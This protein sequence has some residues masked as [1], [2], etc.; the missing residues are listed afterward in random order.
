MSI[1]PNRIVYIPGNGGS[2][3]HRK[4]FGELAPQFRDL[5]LKVVQRKFP[6]PVLARAQYWI[7]F[8]RDELKV[9]ERTVL[10][11]H[12]SGAV[13]ALRYAEQYPI[14]G[15]VV[16]APA[17]TDLGIE[18]EKLSGYFDSPWQWDR[19]R[20]N[21]HF[22]GIFAS[23]D[24]PWIPIE[25]A[26]AVRD[27]LMTAEGEALIDYHEYK[28]KGHFRTNSFPALYKYL[29]RRMMRML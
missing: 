18:E 8:L 24:D 2:S 15:S 3:T 7:P 29:K 23:C 9:D 10:V 21:Q 20:A 14:A 4:W 26:Q 13:C 28:K 1:S 17:V 19:I 5:G 16:V 27:G 25:E 22:V 11:G 6:D 12:S